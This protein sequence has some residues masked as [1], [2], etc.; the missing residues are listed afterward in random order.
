MKLFTV[1]PLA[2][3]MLLTTSPVNN[4][5]YQQNSVTSEVTTYLVLT[6]HGL[7]NGEKGQDNETLFLEN[8]IEYKASIGDALPGSDVITS[9]IDGIT[10]S[11]W[12][13]YEGKGVPTIH[14][15]VPED[16][17]IL[18]ANFT[19][20]PEGG[21][22]GDISMEYDVY[23]K[24]P[25][26]WGE[27]VN[28][29][30]WDDN[31]SAKTSWPGEE[32]ELVS[33]GVYK[34]KYDC[35]VYTNV[36]FNDGTNQTADLKSPMDK[37]MACYVYGIGW[38]ETDTDLTPGTGGDVPIGDVVWY[39]VGEGSFISGSTTW[40]PSTGIAMTPNTAYTGKG[41][42]YMAQGVSFQAGDVWKLCSSENEW[43][44]NGWETE[45]GALHSGDMELVGDGFGGYNV[46]VAVTGTYDIYYKVYG[47]GTYSCWISE[48]K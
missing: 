23:F 37:D 45:S 20:N 4:A 3:C 22:G 21:S 39:I 25:E 15:T 5:T 27:K 16:G 14:T 33:E 9:E 24:A 41:N 35:G 44:A 17:A 10:F 38:C 8:V 34:Y 32:M 31:D 47:D 6:E 26:S 1:L 12:V 18:Y 28:I 11:S 19:A 13:R 43:I 2:L 48:A 36:I 40:S 29:Y 46:S 7:Y 30:I 42:E